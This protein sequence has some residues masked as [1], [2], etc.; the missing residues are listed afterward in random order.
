MT[1][2]G[3]PAASMIT[4][5]QPIRLGHK[6]AVHPHESGGAV[7]KYGVRIGHATAV[8]ATGDWVHLHNCGSDLDER[9]NTLEVMTGSPTDTIYE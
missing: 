3:A 9:S 5:T 7:T 1:L 6:I 4:L 8:I 2:L